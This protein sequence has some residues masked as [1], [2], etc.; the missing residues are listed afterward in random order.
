MTGK[1]YGNCEDADSDAAD[2]E[3]IRMLLNRK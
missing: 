2:G 1:N 3:G